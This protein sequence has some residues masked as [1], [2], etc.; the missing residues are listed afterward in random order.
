MHTCTDSFALVKRAAMAVMMLLSLA[1]GACAASGAGGRGEPRAEAAPAPR[2]RLVVMGM[3]HGEHRRSTAY[4]TGV[5]EGAIRRIRPDAVL[6]EIPPDR[7][8]AARDQFVRTGAISEPRVRVF[9][10]YTEVLFPLWREMGFEIVP[11]AAWTKAMSDD[12]SAKLARWRTERP[13]QTAQVEAAEKRSDERLASASAG[14]GLT[15][16]DPRFIHTDEYDA[17]INDGLEPYDRLF[18]ADLGA[19]G[20]TNINRAHY[21]LIERAIDEAVAKARDG[22]TQTESGAGTAK[23]ATLL[24][25]FGAGHKGW[26]LGRLRTRTD[27]ELVDA[28][29]FFT[30]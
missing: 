9:P 19:G 11:C 17:I 4:S 3:I 6:C 22:G 1:L 23:P 20:W 14:L 25:M 18:N 13:E 5:I 30:P 27:V 28:R 12:R 29:G 2:V 26:F 8:E 15:P 10:E 7:I 24:L 16:D 21:A